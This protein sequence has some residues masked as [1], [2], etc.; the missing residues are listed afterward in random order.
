MKH[1]VNDLVFVLARSWLSSGF[2]LKSS[3]I[4]LY[5]YCYCCGGCVDKWYKWLKGKVWRGILFGDLYCCYLC[6]SKWLYCNQIVSQ[7]VSLSV[8]N[9]VRVPKKISLHRCI[10]LLLYYS[11]SHICF[12][13]VV[14]FR[15]FREE[16]DRKVLLHRW[17]ALLSELAALVACLIHSRGLVFIGNSSATII[18][19][20]FWVKSKNKRSCS[21]IVVGT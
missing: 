7:S 8:S 12:L 6:Y 11:L 21:S 16:N 14:I 13:S 17:S 18:F 2:L 5:C 3:V 9:F 15:D 4:I 20:D 1:Y 10:S 19:A